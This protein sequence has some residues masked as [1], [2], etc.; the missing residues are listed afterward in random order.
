MNKIGEKLIKKS[1]KS[2]GS[3][4]PTLNIWTVFDPKEQKNETSGLGVQKKQF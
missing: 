4:I 1:T 3:R 2:I